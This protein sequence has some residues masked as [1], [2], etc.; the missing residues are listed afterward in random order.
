MSSSGRGLRPPTP[1]F[2]PWDNLFRRPDWTGERTGA[3]TAADWYFAGLGA[4]APVQIP[5]LWLSPP[6]IW[7]PEKPYT[8]AT[9]AGTYTTARAADRASQARYGSRDY[10]ATL[11]TACDADPA[12]LATWV[13]AYYATDPDAAP[14]SRLAR[15]SLRL[16]DRTT[17]EQWRILDVSEGT[18][19]RV[20]GAPST[21]PDGATEQVVEGVRHV[22]G[23]ETRD[24]EWTTSPVVGSAAGTAGPWFRLDDSALDGTDVV[25]F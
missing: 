24:V 15:L 2:A 5:Y 14:R 12:A 16:N 19:I 10:P 21:W 4:P 17:A 13:V 23:D 11:S 1:R 6:A 22:I 25:P 20:T 3:A 8:S 7:R 18:R 9:I